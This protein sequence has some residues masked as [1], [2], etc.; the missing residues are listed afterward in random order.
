M[1]HESDIKTLLA[2]DPTRMAALSTLRSLR[3]P[4]GWIGAGFI[5]DAVWD[6]LHGAPPGQVHGDV[7]VLWHDRERS[8]ADWDRRLEQRLGTCLPS[9]RWS[10]K[11]QA[12]M[13]GRNGDGAYSSVVDAMTH[14]P[15]TATAVAAR[16]SDD[17]DIEISAP[18]GLD[19]LFMGRLVPTPHCSASRLPIFARRVAE[20]RWLTRY[21]S[22]A[23]VIP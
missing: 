8:P 6:H 3:L 19:D 21:P 12:H 7:D 11:N 20:K 16:L 2:T 23:L 5:R 10:V 15:E 4:D 9:L 17:G 22:L 13:H 18:F 1:R 14:W